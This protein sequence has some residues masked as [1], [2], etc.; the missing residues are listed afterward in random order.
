MSVE[1][2]GGVWILRGGAYLVDEHAGV[3]IDSAGNYSVKT[4]G[5]PASLALL[6]RAIA[7]DIEGAK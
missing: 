3:I 4:R 2:V 6:L 5:N 1:R 7:D